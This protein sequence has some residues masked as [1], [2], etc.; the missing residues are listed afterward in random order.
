M[1]SDPPT[2]A[3]FGKGSTSMLDAASLEAIL[4]QA[5][6][7][8]QHGVGLVPGRRT[9]CTWKVRAIRSATGRWSWPTTSCSASCDSC[10]LQLWPTGQGEAVLGLVDGAV[11]HFP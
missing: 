2:F 6:D 7:C 3:E 8:P 5:R 4:Q 1:S 10:G 9:T 11:A